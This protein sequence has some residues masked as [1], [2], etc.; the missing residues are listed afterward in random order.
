MSLSISGAFSTETVGATTESYLYDPDKGC[1]LLDLP[2]ELFYLVS[3]HLNYH[4]II[5]LSKTCSR[6][7]EYINSDVFWTRLIYCQFHSSIAKLY[8]SDIFNDKRNQDVINRR[9]EI[10]QPDFISKKG[11]EDKLDQAA[12]TCCTHYN[13]TAVLNNG[14]SMYISQDQF[15]HDV[16]YY[17]YKTQYLT[18]NNRKNTP[19]M[20]LIYFY[21][22][23]RKRLAAIN[24]GVV[25]LNNNYLI[26]IKTSDSLNGHVVQLNTVCW[27]DIS[28]EMENILPG[29]YELIWRMKLSSNC[30]IPGITE[31]IAVPQHG[32]LICCKWSEENFREKKIEYGSQWF[33]T[34]M[35]TT[36]IY[37]PSTVLI[38]VR[39]LV[40]P[41]W[42]NGVSWD[43][44]ELKL[45]P[46]KNSSLSM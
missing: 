24:M 5:N 25:H 12:I 36:N 3:E 2:P 38:A 16:K 15:R 10:R 11:N 44:V 28:G 7:Y 18:D 22:I 23:D 27:L 45:V 43:C 39:N 37:E 29:K 17:Q 31:F 40:N 21:L 6:L 41:Y 4:D 20:K 9:N 13:E 32:S 8:T 14:T 46:L 35:G 1:L 42:K 34:E 30:Y 19:L 26:G 33:T